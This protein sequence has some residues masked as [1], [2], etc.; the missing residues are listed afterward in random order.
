MQKGG[1]QLKTF[2]C[3]FTRTMAATIMRRAVMRAAQTA[4]PVRAVSSSPKNSAAAGT[5]ATH[6]ASPLSPRLRGQCCLVRSVCCLVLH[7]FAHIESHTH[8]FNNSRTETGGQLL[9]EWC[10][11]AC[12]AIVHG[13][14]GDN[15]R[16]PS[17][18]RCHDAVS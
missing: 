3:H 15:A 8:N 10:G 18:P 2:I 7:A 16:G 14:A 9:H 11:D 5:H 1:R 12:E 17:R 4:W 13:H 6:A